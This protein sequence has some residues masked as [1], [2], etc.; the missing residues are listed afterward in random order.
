MT[1]A[2]RREWNRILEYNAD[3]FRRAEYQA[4]ID[5]LNNLTELP[6]LFSKRPSWRDKLK[7]WSPY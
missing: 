6:K 4:C 2:E 5:Y 3:K 1:P 7:G